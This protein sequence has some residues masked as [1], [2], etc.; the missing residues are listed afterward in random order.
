MA[1]EFSNIVS[2]LGKNFVTLELV[3]KN[4]AGVEPI[5]IVTGSTAMLRQDLIVQQLARNNDQAIEMLNTI[6]YIKSNQ[7]KFEVVDLAYLDASEKRLREFININNAHVV[8]CFDDIFGGCQVPEIVLPSFSAPPRVQRGNALCAEG[9]SWSETQQSCCQENKHIICEFVTSS[10]L[11][12][13][14]RLQTNI[15]C[16]EGT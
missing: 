10:G 14:Q 11:C 13:L 9:F 6:T 8:A 16:Q 3:A 4:Y 5:N 12:L 7:H 2:L 15:M 1:R